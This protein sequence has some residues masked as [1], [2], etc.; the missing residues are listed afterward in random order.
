ML[1]QRAHEVR[2]EHSGKFGAES[3]EGRV[4]ALARLRD[5]TGY[6]AEVGPRHGTTRE[7]LEHNC[8]ILSIASH[9]PEACEVERR[10]FQSLLRADVNTSH[11][12][13]AGAPVCRFLIR[14]L[15][16]EP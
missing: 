16:E 5:E 6:M 3:L 12:V 11:R 9:Y 14:P 2:D 4:R 1:Q 7:L 15:P 10:L 13:V 8:P